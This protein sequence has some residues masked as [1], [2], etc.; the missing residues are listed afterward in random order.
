MKWLLLLLVPALASAQEPSPIAAAAA[1]PS[2]GLQT[3]LQ[4]ALSENK[5][6]VTAQE[7]VPQAMAGR[8]KAWA[9]IQPN[10]DL[11]LQYRVNDREIAFDM[12]ELGDGLGDAFGGIYGNLGFIYGELFQLGTIDGDDCNNLAEINGFADCDE[13]TNVF[14]EGGDIEPDTDTGDS[15]PTVIQ[16]KEQFFF[17]AQVNWPLS[18]RVIPLAVAGERQVDAARAQ[19]QQIKEQVVYGVVQAYAGAYG[20]QESVGL[21]LNQVELA[22]AHHKDTEALFRAGV[23]TKDVL[24]RAQVEEQKIILQLK[25]AQQ[26]HRTARRGLGLLMGTGIGGH[27]RLE[28]LPEVVVDASATGEDWAEDAIEQRPELRGAQAQALAAKNME[29]D[30]GLQFLP[31]VAFSG[32]YNWTDQSAGFDDKQGSWWI[33]IGG[34]I[35]VWDGG[36]RVHQAREAASRRR[37]AVANIEALRQQVA[38]EAADAWDSWASAQDS[39]PVAKQE[40][41]L[42]AEAYRLAEV[43]YRAG[44]SRQVEILDARAV[45]QGAELSLLQAQISERVA[46]VRLMQAVGEA[47]TWANGLGG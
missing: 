35:P 29:I 5:N 30:A 16:P 13:L 3:A 2:L 15:E 31:T 39:L 28:P 26:A 47:R 9:F 10:I 17:N 42:A 37:Q 20:A 6:L 22:A 21:L 33:G 1:A 46:G 18:P 4:T 34:S 36:I 19:L 44:A 25:Q 38:T 8:D 43:R 7:L 41:D 32:S 40:R 24:L 23:I 12:S 14:L 45:L 11:G 27:G